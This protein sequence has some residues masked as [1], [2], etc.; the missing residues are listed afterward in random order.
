M[1]S[2]NHYSLGSCAEWLYSHVLG[3][4]LSEDKPICIS[5]SFS[6]ELSFAKGEYKAKDGKIRVEWKYA[7][8]AYRLQVKADK[9]VTFDYDFGDRAVSVKRRGNVLYAVIK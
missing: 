2:F 4:K 7:D 6:K 1:N 9:N 5:P 8:G 3:I